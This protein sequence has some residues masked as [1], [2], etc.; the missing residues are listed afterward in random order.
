MLVQK[1][2]HRRSGHGDQDLMQGLWVCP[3]IFLWN[4]LVQILACWVS[5]C[6]C[7]ECITNKMVHLSNIIIHSIISYRTDNI[8]NKLVQL[9]YT[10]IF[11]YYLS[12]VSPLKVHLR[13][14]LSV[15][16][17]MMAPA[18]CGSG[19]LRPVSMLYT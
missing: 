7:S 12:K 2:G 14:R 15:M 3:L 11:T 18:S 17:K 5:G 4:L 13:Q 9:I 19:Q 8:T 10:L 6:L 1:L 16:T